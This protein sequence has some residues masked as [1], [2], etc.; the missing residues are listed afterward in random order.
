MKVKTRTKRIL[1]RLL[2]SITI[3][4]T[5]LSLVGIIAGFGNR[6]YAA[7]DG[8]NITGAIESLGVSAGLGLL[9]GGLPLIIL[10]LLKLVIIAIGLLLQIIISGAFSSLESGFEWA[11]LSDIIFA[12]TGDASKFLDINFFNITGSNTEPLMVFR[13]AIAKWYY[14]LRL[15]SAAILLVILIY[16]GIR[17][18]ISTI[19]SEQAKYKQ[20]LTDWITSLA[21]LF[22]LHYIIMFVISIN[23]SLVTTIGGI[24]DDKTGS[25]IEAITLMMFYPG[26]EGIFAAIVYVV[27]V[28][29][30]F[31]FFL[32][33]I[34]RMI[35]VGFLIM[36]APLITITY[37]ID[38]IGD[39]KAQALNTWL[40]ELVYNILIQPFHCIIF[41]AFFD[42]IAQIINR[43]PLSIGAYIFAIVIMQF[44]KKAEEILRKIFHFEANSMSSL[45]ESGQS[46][47]NATGTFV[48]TGVMAGGAVASF[49]AAGGIKAAK[50]NW[51]QF[52]LDKKNK[53]DFRESFNQ[54]KK[55]GL[56]ASGTSF[57]DYKQSDAGK[58]E[59]ANI[60][61]TNAADMKAKADAKQANKMN[62]SRRKYDK[63]NGEG[64][65]DEMIEDRARKKFDKEHGEGSYDLT[66]KVAA[67][68]DKYGRSTKTAQEAQK[69]INNANIKEMNAFEKEGGA[70]VK[71]TLK[72]G[73]ANTGGRAY[74]GM[75]T[76]AGTD[77]GK[78]AIA[79]AKDSTRIAAMIGMGAFGLGAGDLK[80]AISLGQ[81][82][83]GFTTGL[84]KQSTG[85]LVTDSAEKA[86]QIAAITG[87]DAS[88]PEVI[89]KILASITQQ[90][91]SG[92]LDPKAIT[93][94]L[95]QLEK[96]ITSR[97]TNKNQGSFDANQFRLDLEA[98]SKL[99]QLNSEKAISDLVEKNFGNLDNE[100]KV[101]IEV[102]ARN[103]INTVLMSGVATNQTTMEGAGLDVDEHDSKVIE[104]ANN[105]HLS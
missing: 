81:A 14:I 40:K 48:K 58:A 32:M 41:M 31:S 95:D 65:Y 77:F 45:K 101:N 79:S 9:M 1:I 99:G 78:V 17:M 72:N 66:K 44:M 3:I 15:I 2:S 36:I 24:T 29:Q 70:G 67:G 92:Q 73:W 54:K 100:S 11:S 21:L 57:D 35:T 53:R 96:A 50:Q 55:N 94:K 37:S 83:Y 43:T 28:G 25:M 38:K 91:Q 82:G 60:V 69:R 84:L 75:K 27:Y 8:F 61:K 30:I 5:I 51:K 49:K 10:N 80:D 26:M 18:A 34:K 59:Y 71:R 23:T 39:G 93:A 98:A 56:L 13:T 97:Y 89:Q 12:G 103:Y 90:K 86:Q 42:A 64:A 68:V 6:S 52:K 76:F 19:A 46:I 85:T 105:V 102:E 22:L 104:K 4:Y 16:V 7:D 33:Y 62:K 63:K 88:D 87:Q 47:A 20:M 74:R